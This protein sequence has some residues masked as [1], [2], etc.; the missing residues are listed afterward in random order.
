MKN[1]KI[2]QFI[3]LYLQLSNNCIVLYF[4]LLLASTF[5][6]LFLG[7]LYSDSSFYKTKDR[8]YPT[9]NEQMKM[10][11]MIS[12]ILEAPDAMRSRG[13]KM[14]LKRKQ[15]AEQH[16]KEAMGRKFEKPYDGMDAG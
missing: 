14:Y 6:M 11:R 4:M 10:C 12:G 15:G 5:I 13:G 7:D 8:M 1:E 16:A 3:V 2:F 9:I